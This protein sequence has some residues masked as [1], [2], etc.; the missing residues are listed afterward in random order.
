MQS[1]R[2]EKVAVVEE[3]RERLGASSA[4][5]C[6]EYRGLAVFELE[7]LRR[8]LSATGADYKIFKNSLARRAAVESGFSV[9]E[10]YLIGPTGLVFVKDDVAAVAKTL[11]DFARVHPALVVK[12]GVIG[13]SPL[14]ARDA[15]ALADLPSRDVLLAQLA[16]ALAAP[17][18]QFAGLLKA[19]P[20]SLAYGIQALIDQRGGAPASAEPAPCPDAPVA[21]TV[22]PDASSD[23]PTAS[24]DTPTD[25]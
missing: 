8:A 14:D 13:T 22:D 7:S 24:S 15:A 25:I 4:A 2:P 21:A 18:R 10:P 5:L 3:V 23:T 19:V 12:G 16:G 11:R 17:M 20:Q 9:L 1:P 6:T